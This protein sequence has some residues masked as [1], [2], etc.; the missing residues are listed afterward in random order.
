MVFPKLTFSSDD[1]C[2][3]TIYEYHSKQQ[4]VLQEY[5]N[6]FHMNPHKGKFSFVATLTER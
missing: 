3:V 2:I 4:S 6:P 1:G 5:L